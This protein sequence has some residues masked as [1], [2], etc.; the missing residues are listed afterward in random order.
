MNNLTIKTL[1]AV[2]ILLSFIQIGLLSFLLR[3]KIKIAKEKS[4]G[5]D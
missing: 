2:V 1:F 5:R 3:K 4:K